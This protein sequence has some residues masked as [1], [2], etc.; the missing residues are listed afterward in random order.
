MRDKKIREFLLFTYFL[1]LT[2]I[3][4]NASFTAA[5]RYLAV[6]SGVVTG[7]GPSDLI[8][9][10]P[11]IGAGGAS[12]TCSVTPSAVGDTLLMAVAAQ[13]AVTNVTDNKGNTWVN[14]TTNGDLTKTAA[15]S[16]Y[17]YIFRVQSAVS[18]AAT[19]VTIT[20]SF[21]KTAVYIL[22]VKN[23][24]GTLDKTSTNSDSTGTSS[25]LTTGSTAALSQA[26]EFAVTAC[27]HVNGGADPQ[28][29]GPTGGFTGLTA[30]QSSTVNLHVGYITSS[31]TSALSTGWTITT[32]D[33]W[34]CILA[35]YK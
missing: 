4:C 15:G 2:S 31:S 30:Q 13:I 32:P 6:Q 23:I 25:N 14:A 29:S 21:G 10:T 18:A 19:T 28:T 16:Y 26:S 24:A 11:C 3:P 5:Q 8:S 27:Q 17:T 22:D 20:T 1:F 33:D 35:T 9:A 34:N 7:G 12:F